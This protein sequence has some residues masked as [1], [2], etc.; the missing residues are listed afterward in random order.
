MV[1]TSAG[2]TM[3]VPASL[4]QSTLPPPHTGRRWTAV[5][6][7]SQDRVE[8]MELL[9]PL[10]QFWPR[11]LRVERNTLQ[12]AALPGR[13]WLATGLARYRK[14]HTSV[15]GISRKS[16][17]NSRRRGIGQEKR[18][19]A[20]SREMEKVLGWATATQWPAKTL[21]FQT[22]RRAITALELPA[23]DQRTLEKPPQPPHSPTSWRRSA[24]AAKGRIGTSTNERSVYPGEGVGGPRREEKLAKVGNHK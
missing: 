15:F 18:S 7:Q 19:R 1:S 8:E 11:R 12:P 23:V 5:A 22:T 9:S 16:C 14:T 2:A 20:L 13:L 21:D 3:S 4:L 24:S 17:W 10:P 6:L